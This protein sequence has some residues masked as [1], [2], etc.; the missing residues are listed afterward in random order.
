MDFYHRNYFSN[1]I[2]SDLNIDNEKKDLKYIL[3]L[4]AIFRK[5][6]KSIFP[7]FYIFKVIAVNYLYQ[8][9]I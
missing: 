8:S 9:D 1:F 5:I 6:N 4:Y 2:S 7:N 3:I